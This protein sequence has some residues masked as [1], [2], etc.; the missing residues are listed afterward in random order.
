MSGTTAEARE[1]INSLSLPPFAHAR[2][3]ELERYA[4]TC[5]VA[6][7]ERQLELGT[8]YHRCCWEPADGDHHAACRAAKGVAA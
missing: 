5:G 6:A 3:R 1:F 4:E 8:Q 2:R 7:L